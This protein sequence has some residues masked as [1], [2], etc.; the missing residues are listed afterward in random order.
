MKGRS[1]PLL[2]L[3]TGCEL[4]P[5]FHTS[6]KVTAVHCVYVYSVKTDI[7]EAGAKSRLFIANANIHDSG[8]YSCALGEVAS[9][10]VSVHVLNGKSTALQFFIPVKT[11]LRVGVVLPKELVI[12]LEAWLVF[13]S[14]RLLRLL[15]PTLRTRVQN[16]FCGHL[17]EY[18]VSQIPISCQQLWLGY[19]GKPCGEI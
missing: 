15:D 7:L 13:Y 12:P 16:N 1:H 4:I 9:T 5:L 19:T 14:S 2:Y 10:T 8:N 6:D 11:K 3:W 17:F 18:V